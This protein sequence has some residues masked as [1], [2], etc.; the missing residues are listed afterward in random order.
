MMILYSSW[1]PSVSGS[2]QVS[3]EVPTLPSLRP[4][5]K[6]KPAPTQT[7][8]L[9]WSFFLL[10][11]VPFIGAPL[12]IVAL[13]KPQLFV[14]LVHQGPSWNKTCSWT[15]RTKPP[16]MVT[17][18]SGTC[19]VTR[20]CSSAPRC[21]TRPTTRWSSCCGRYTTWTLERKCRDDT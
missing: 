11:G 20:T 2:I 16:M 4:N 3:G 19:H 9:D 15:E 1:K 21:T 6:P 10:D 12:W 13:S 8:N 5:P 14:S 18:H 7:R 17:W